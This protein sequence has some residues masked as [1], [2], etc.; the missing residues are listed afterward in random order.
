MADEV[1][2]TQSTE[3]A[4]EG[5]AVKAKN[6]KINRITLND[7]AVKIEEIEKGN[8]TGSKYYK[9]LLQRKREMEQS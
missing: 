8:A 3:G 2:A 6:K 5:A 1:Q 9:H 7:L 4:T